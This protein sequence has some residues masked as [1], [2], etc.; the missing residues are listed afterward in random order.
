MKK[1]KCE[2]CGANL[3]IEDNNEYAYCE[4]CNL[5]YKLND[6]FN[7]NFKIDDNISKTTSKVGTIIAITFIFVFIII[8]VVV[9]FFT[10]KIGSHFNNIN[11]TTTKVENKTDN[12]E[13]G[14]DSTT[15]N[16]FYYAFVGTKSKFEIES[17]FDLVSTN[18]KTNKKHIINIK[19]NEIEINDSNDIKNLK[20]KLEDKDYEV[21][22]DYDKDGF[23]NKITLEDI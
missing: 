4:Y 5:K 12:S 11:K 18:N 8:A 22:F 17:M 14:E 16:F 9:I 20:Q 15:F 13:I 7:I 1:L 2:N 21:V 23:I 6:S 10:S 3:K 19:Y